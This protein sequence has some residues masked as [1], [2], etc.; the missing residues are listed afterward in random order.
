M[1]N[2]ILEAYSTCKRLLID[3]YDKLTQIARYLLANEIAEGDALTKLFES[4]A[5]PL[6]GVVAVGT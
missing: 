1:E 3:N 6:E 4:E 2:I 5:P